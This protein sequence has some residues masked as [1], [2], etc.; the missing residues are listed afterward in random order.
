MQ[1]VQ[2]LHDYKGHADNF[3]C[4]VI[5][6]ASSAQYTPGDPLS[7]SIKIIICL[8]SVTASHDD[9]WI[10]VNTCIGGLLFKMS[11]GNMQYVTSTSFL[12]VTYAKYL[13]SAHMFVNC[14]GTTITPSRLRNIAKKQV[15]KDK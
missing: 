7:V 5:P 10:L 6:G 11:D 1:N 8:L 3:I 15:K 4:S 9:F 13:T 14:G 2:S 12:L